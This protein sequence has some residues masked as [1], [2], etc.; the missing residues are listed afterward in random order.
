MCPAIAPFFAPGGINLLGAASMATAIF[1]EIRQRMQ[2]GLLIIRASKPKNWTMD[3]TVNPSSVEVKKGDDCRTL[4][5]PPEVRIVPSSCRGLQYV[6]GDGLHVRLLVQ[7]GLSTK[8]ISALE[9][10][11]K[12]KKSC[13]FYC[14]TCGEIIIKD[15]TFLRVL[16]LPGENWSDLVEDWCCHPNPF[17]SSLLQPRTDDCFLGHNYFLVNLGSES[18][19]SSPE[20]LPSQSQGAVSG[21]SGSTLNSKANSRV[22]CKRCKTLLGEA[23]STGVTKYYFT[24]LLVRPSEKQF[25]AIPRSLFIQSIIAQCLV[26]LSS[27]R[28]TF[29]FSIQGTEGTVYILVWLLNSDTLLV[30]TSG[31]SASSNNFTFFEDGVASNLKSSDI[32]NAIK[33]L[34]HPCLKSRNKELVDAWENDFGVHPLTFPTKTCLELLLIMAQSNAAL[35]PS[36]RCM[37]SFEVAFL[38]M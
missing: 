18:T 31:N 15:R 36:L 33:V 38:K 5:L 4:S 30:E 25:E 12:S 17:N 11:L 28:S 16:S 37:N 13:T 21:N 35:P 26:E 9:D 3:I 7:A 22:I 20:L 2:S 23:L 27:S 14:Q 1:L 34:Y 10:S 29:R 6:P 8:S 24:E 19:V 32:R